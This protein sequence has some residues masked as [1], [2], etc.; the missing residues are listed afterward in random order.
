[1]VQENEM[2]ETIEP[3]G[4]SET[5][6]VETTTATSDRLPRAVGPGDIRAEEVNFSQGGANTIEAQ[7]V[8]ITQGGAASV[9]ADDFSISQGGVAVARTGSLTIGEAGNSF[10]VVADKATVEEGGSVFLLVAGSA[11]GDVRPALDWRTALAL[12][13][14]FG[15]AISLIRRVLR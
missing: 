11:S 15:L 4:A 10:M 12:G 8:S 14:G 2:Q 7:K 6:G 3:E 5:T 1:M 13:A 9:R